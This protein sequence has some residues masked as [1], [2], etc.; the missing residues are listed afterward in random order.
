MKLRDNTDKQVRKERRIK[1]EG[2]KEGE[3][4]LQRERPGDGNE[5]RGDKRGEKVSGANWE[6]W[7]HLQPILWSHSTV[8]M[9]RRSGLCVY[10][11]AHVRGVSESISD[12]WSNIKISS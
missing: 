8:V 12:G 2:K 1:G 3:E 11:C 5:G 9:T 10:F 7:L 4:K 6:A